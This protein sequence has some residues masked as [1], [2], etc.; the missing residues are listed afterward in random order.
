MSTSD[1]THVSWW[2]IGLPEIVPVFLCR[3]PRKIRAVFLQGR[4]PRSPSRSRAWKGGK[5]VQGLPQ[6][7]T[8]C[9][10]GL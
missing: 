9:I 5:P 7:C 2:R 6:E 4:R 10:M 3:A 1:G 8:E